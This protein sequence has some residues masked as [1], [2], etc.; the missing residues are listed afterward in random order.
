ML[1]TLPIYQDI[2]SQRAAL[3][4]V[5]QAITNG[6]FLKTLAAAVVKLDAAAVSRQVSLAMY[7][8]QACLVA[9]SFS[10]AWE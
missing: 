3:G 8:T 5:R 10:V 1:H 7:S 2:A 4:T 6:T 9:C